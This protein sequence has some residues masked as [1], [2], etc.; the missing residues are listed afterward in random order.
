MPLLRACGPRQW[1]TLYSLPAVVQFEPVH[2]MTLKDLLQYLLNT[3]GAPRHVATTK[4]ALAPQT[5]NRKSTRGAGSRRRWNT[6]SMANLA[7]IWRKKGQSGGRRMREKSWTK[8]W[9][10]SRRG[11]TERE[12]NHGKTKTPLSKKRLICPV[13]RKP[14]WELEHVTYYDHCNHPFTNN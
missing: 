12:W 1:C 4:R 8:S 6:R 14:D 11:E 13:R 10:S 9:G 7:P 5:S 3:A 2:D